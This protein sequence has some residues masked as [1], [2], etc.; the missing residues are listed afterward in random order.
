M[1]EFENWLKKLDTAP[2]TQIS[3]DPDQVI[4]GIQ[5]RI[6]YRK[7]RRQLGYAVTFTAAIVLVIFTIMVGRSDRTKPLETLAADAGNEVFDY[8]LAVSLLDSNEVND[9]YWSAAEYMLETSS[10]SQPLPDIQLTST[11]MES[12]TKYL[13]EQNS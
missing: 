1:N 3:P 7:T 2:E 12:F 4:A 9:L 11:E 13:E 10:I 6:Q 8:S 5:A